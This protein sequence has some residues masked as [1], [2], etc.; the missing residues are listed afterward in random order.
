MEALGAFVVPAPSPHEYIE[1][2]SREGEH[3]N[4]ELKERFA[5]E[6]QKGFQG[7]D[8]FQGPTALSKVLDNHLVEPA[9]QGYSGI[10]WSWGN[11][12]DGVHGSVV[13]MD[14]RISLCLF[15]FSFFF[16][17]VFILQWRLFIY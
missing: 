5:L 9:H 8:V 12:L 14:H 16:K 15:L 7:E 6:R 3:I 17:P 4:K 13:S 1:K 11:D 2:I 10:P